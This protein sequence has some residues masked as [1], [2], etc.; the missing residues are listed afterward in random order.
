M[1]G[2]RNNPDKASKTTKP[3]VGRRGLSPSVIA[4]GM[5]LIGNIVSDGALDIDGKIDGNVRGQTVSVRPNGTIHGDVTADTVHVHGEVNGTIK[6]RNVMLYADSRITGIIIHESITIEDGASVDGKFKRTEK[7]QI[8]EEDLA[9]RRRLSAPTVDVSFSGDN[10]N[11]FDDE[12]Q[13]EAEIRILENL[14]LVN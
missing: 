6:A 3:T 9:I 1:F 12:P 8:D 14:R 10:D 13:S 4:E 7:V 11:A 2:R 5:H